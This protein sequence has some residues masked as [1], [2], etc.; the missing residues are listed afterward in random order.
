MKTQIFDFHADFRA[1]FEPRWTQQCSQNNKSRAFFYNVPRRHGKTLFAKL[2]TMLNPHVCVLHFGER[3]R[4]NFGA[5]PNDYTNSN[6]IP[7]GSFVILDG[8]IDVFPI[9]I[10]TSVCQRMKT[11][12]GTVMVL[13]SPAFE[14]EGDFLVL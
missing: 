6:D 5:R 2:I 10:I 14:G 7:D 12:G 4:V 9:E 11:T 1:E 3:N 8:G 13:G